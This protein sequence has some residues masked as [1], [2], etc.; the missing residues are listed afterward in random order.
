MLVSCVL[1]IF[2]LF[3]L[4]RFVLIVC[5]HVMLLQ[6]ID[7]S[8]VATYGFVFLFCFLSANFICQETGYFH[9]H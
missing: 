6:V 3:S 9:N 7:F 2:C 8:V 4:K 5:L 1:L